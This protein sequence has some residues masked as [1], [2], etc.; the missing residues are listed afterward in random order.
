MEKP[1]ISIV[2]PIYKSEPYLAKCVDSILGQT[3][4]NFEVILVDD[5]SP[6]GSGKICDTYAL[7]DSRIRVFHKANGGV[8]RARNFGIDN[9]TGD[10][11]AF[12]D[13]D[14]FV[15]EDYLDGFFQCEVDSDLFVQGYRQ[16]D[17][18]HNTSAYLAFEM[19]GMFEDISEPYFWAEKNGVICSPYVKLFKRQILNSRNI[20]FDN[21]LTNGEDLLFV[22]NYMLHIKNVCLSR[23]HSYNYIIRAEPSL[24][25]RFISCEEAQGFL[26]RV[27]ELRNLV[28]QV[29]QIKSLE[30]RDYLDFLFSNAYLLSIMALYNGKAKLSKKVRQQK[31]AKCME[32]LDSEP[33]IKNT[34]QK[35]IFMRIWRFF[36]VNSVPFKDTIL[37]ILASLRA[38]KN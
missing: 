8:S 1:K 37:F 27:T 12:I 11:V 21:Q 25:K 32:F 22:L 35:T 9:A 18:V 13:S 30:C 23:K 24:S 31:L 34:A 10:Y 20:R 28:V 3:Y 15:E 5:G 26:F 14:D 6:D 16:I 2:V 36:V 7:K 38:L 19:D 33:V 4:P 17:M 29:H